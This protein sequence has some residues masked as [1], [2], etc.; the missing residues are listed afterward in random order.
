MRIVLIGPPGSGK[1]TQGPLI[2]EKLEVP[3]VVVSDLL[4]AEI[5]SGGALATVLS[6]HMNRGE[7][8]PDAVITGLVEARLRSVVDG[9]LLDGFPRTVEQARHLDEL[10]GG[11]DAQID[12]ALHFHVPTPVLVQRLTERGRPDDVLGI[13]RARLR[14]YRDVEGDLL[15]HYVTRAVTLDA[16]GTVDEVHGRAMAGLAEITLP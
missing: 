16:V 3:L 15:Q 2:A 11:H 12:V 4:R 1:G 9:F 5:A 7:L 13:A 14:A 8:V 10:L 6:D